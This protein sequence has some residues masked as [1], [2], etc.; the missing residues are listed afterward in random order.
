MSDDA[1]ASQAPRQVDPY[2]TLELHPKASRELVTLAYWALVAHARGQA[3]GEKRIEDLNAAYEFLTDEARRRAYN[4]RTGL[5]MP[6]APV[7]QLERRH[8]GLLGTRTQLRLNAV[9]D[10]YHLLRVDPEASDAV[11]YAAYDTLVRRNP[12]GSAEAAMVRQLLDEARRVLLN[13][14]LRA[15]YDASRGSGPAPNTGVPSPKQPVPAPPVAT[16]SQ[17]Q[18]YRNGSAPAAGPP[19]RKRQ[20]TNGVAAVSANGHRAND[21][22]HAPKGKVAIIAAEGERLLSL[23]TDE[24]LDLGANENTRAA[25]PAP[26]AKPASAGPPDAALITLAGP[27][28]GE[29]I[30]LGL[31][32]VAIGPGRNARIVV[33][34]AESRAGSEYA[35]VW[36]RGDRVFLRQAGQ[37]G[38][39]INGQPLALPLVILDDGDEIG[40]AGQVLRF[41]IGAESGISPM[42]PNP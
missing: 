8:T 1:L 39:K 3:H 25:P 29:K 41:Q 34:S 37:N 21:R 7:L 12:E 16:P 13:P 6:G 4:A 33:P 14:Q 20:H 36:R 27:H 2:R 23:R 17:P 26:A 42:P 40:I 11:I 30:A 35:R 19:S 9:A 5:P 18:P 24:V 31:D 15:R 22:S 32:P 28:A 10:H 38:V